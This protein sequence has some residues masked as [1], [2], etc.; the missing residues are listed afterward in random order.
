LL[1]KYAVQVRYLSNL[2]PSYI[3]MPR[4]C[5]TFT[6][7]WGKRSKGGSVQ[8]GLLGKADFLWQDPMVPRRPVSQ[9]PG[10]GSGILSE[11]EIL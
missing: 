10:N 8:L 6:F 3:W 4:A 5:Y 7:P 1:A 11:T 2:D 9:G